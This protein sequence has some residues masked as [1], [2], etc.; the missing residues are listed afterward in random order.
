[1]VGSNDERNKTWRQSAC[2]AGTAVAVRLL[3]K[4][5]SWQPRGLR[6]LGRTVSQMSAHRCVRGGMIRGSSRNHHRHGHPD[7]A[8]HAKTN[9]IFDKW[10]KERQARAVTQGCDGAGDVAQRR[11][12]P[13]RSALAKRHPADIT[14]ATQ[15][16]ALRPP[17]QESITSS[18]G[19]SRPRS[20]AVEQDHQLTMRVSTAFDAAC[21]PSARWGYRDR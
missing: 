4:F 1:M 12:F 19:S 3:S 17:E 9:R 13:A 21:R 20:E 10:R 7:E 5:R 11:R 15:G 8:D 16:T 6:P 2:R 14:R 18:E